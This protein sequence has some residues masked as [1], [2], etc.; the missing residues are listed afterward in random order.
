MR[1]DNNIH[2]Y[3]F[4][5]QVVKVMNIPGFSQSDSIG[6]IHYEEISKVYEEMILGRYHFIFEE[7]LLTSE[8]DNSS[9]HSKSDTSSQQR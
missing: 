3:P 9:S 7:E 5:L 6:N 1:L 4:G 8:G 2:F